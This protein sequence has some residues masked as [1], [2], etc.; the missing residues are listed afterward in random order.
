MF[1]ELLHV[2]L[3]FLE[4]NLQNEVYIIKGVVLDFNAVGFT[5]SEIL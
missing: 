2:N 3:I 4:Y 1:L 5:H